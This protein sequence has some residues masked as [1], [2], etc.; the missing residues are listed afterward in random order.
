MLSGAWKKMWS[1]AKVAGIL[2]ALSI[3][4][5]IIFSSNSQLAENSNAASVLNS[6]LTI[7]KQINFS[8]GTVQMT[9][10]YST[11][12]AY[13]EA[14]FSA[15]IVPDGATK[16]VA[17]R[18]DVMVSEASIVG[19][20]SSLSV[21]LVPGLNN[22]G[23]YLSDDQGD[24]SEVKEGA[25]IV[26]NTTPPVIYT[27]CNVSD[28]QPFVAGD[29]NVEWACV[30]FGQFTTYGESYPVPI[31][32]SVSANISKVTV[33]G[34]ELTPGKNGYINQSVTLPTKTGT[35]IYTIVA[36]DDLGNMSTEH[37]DEEMTPTN[38]QTSGGGGGGGSG[39][40]K[41]CTTGQ[42]CGDSCISWSYTCHKGPGCACQG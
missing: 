13:H 1:G 9:N 11:R 25:L 19:G 20:K 39:C 2:A 17:Y 4:A 24:L 16:L 6:N 27:S 36:K 23:F 14:S 15:D 30:A 10:D 29:S 38:T 35:N 21:A 37:F 32:G 18:D 7:T 28:G 34:K 5:G 22:L 40:C 26:Y 8:V 41:V 12:T 3:V 33:N 42:A 31:Y